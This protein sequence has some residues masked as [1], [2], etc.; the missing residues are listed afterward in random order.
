MLTDGTYIKAVLLLL[1]FSLNTLVGSAC[2][3]SKVFHQSHHHQ[4]SAMH[5]HGEGV[6]HEHD[7]SGSHHDAGEEGEDCC[8][9]SSVAFNHL[10]KSVAQNFA[11]PVLTFPVHPFTEFYNTFLLLRRQDDGTAITYT[12]WRPPATIQ[13]LRIVMQ[14]F[15]I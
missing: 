6:K 7:H 4:S 8:S 9:R 15:Q 12:R 14:S 10:D 5:S 3:L 2:S 1:V 13:D 11:T